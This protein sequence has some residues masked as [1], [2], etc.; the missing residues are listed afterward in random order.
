[1]NILLI[2]NGG[3]EHAIA[4]ALLRSSH[5][6]K[7]YVFA[8]KVNPGLRELADKY[9]LA[10]TLSD[11]EELREFVEKVK[12]DFAFIGPDN[13]IADG[14]ADFLETLGVPSV[15]PK[16][17]PA[18]LE[19]S[20]Y[21]TRELLEKHFIPGNPRFRQF[22]SEAGVME[23]LQELGD[24]YVVK[25]D[26]LAFGKGV[27]VAGDHLRNHEDA[28]KFVR[29][30]LAVHPSVVLEEK[31]EGV[32]FSL[33]AF[34][35][36]EHLAFMPAVQDHKR[37][38]E[39]DEGPNTGGMGSY[40]DANHSMPFL[41]DEDVDMACH[42]SQEVLKAVNV[43][44]GQAFKG[45][46]YGGFMATKDGVKL[47]EYNARFGD[48]EAMNVLPL[49]E[50]DF[51]EVCQAIIAGTLNKLPVKFSTKATVCLYVVPEGY[52]DESM[53]GES[54]KIGDMPEGVELFYSSVNEKD[55]QVMTTSSRSIG[56]VGI[57]D[58][59]EEARLKAVEGVSNISGEIFYRKD[60][61]SPEL[62]GKR[63][64]M[65]KKIRG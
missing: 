24:K 65:M 10:S 12:P 45:I 61:G 26:G 55:G 28:L 59:I 11:T 40:S 47:I 17:A 31:L 41:S 37:A 22:T 15:A 1:M 21:F 60:I 33:M 44:T 52:P 6:P 20:K 4:K 42:I 5:Q 58:S 8:N 16:K 51:V 14:V 62:I 7:L 30:C 32:E 2:G 64:E 46:L 56:V 18:Q 43:E 36:G 50:T 3:R 63:V 35:D 29:E 38:Y 13:P 39:G 49:L 19:S 23:F 54:L 57:A 25:A 34:A 27:K 53:V 48:P 9:R